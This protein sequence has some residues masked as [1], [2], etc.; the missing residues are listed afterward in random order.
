MLVKLHMV[1][2]RR[3][4]FCHGWCLPLLLSCLE[5]R[6]CTTDSF[7][8]SEAEEADGTFSLLQVA[9]TARRAAPAE[10]GQP[11]HNIS[12]VEPSSVVLADDVS[13]RNKLPNYTNTNE[14]THLMRICEFPNKF[15]TASSPQYE[16]Q[17]F[18]RKC[19]QTRTADLMKE[20]NVTGDE[21]I[22]MG[23]GDLV[24]YN[25]SDELIE[26]IM[27]LLQRALAQP[28]LMEGML[29][30]ANNTLVVQQRSSLHDIVGPHGVLM[31][32]LDSASARFDQSSRLLSQVGIHVERFG[33]TDDSTA[34]PQELAEGCMKNTS[35]DVKTFCL[36]RA[37][38][39]CLGDTE[40]AIALSH[41]K[42]LEWAKKRDG[43][44]TAVFEDDAV[45]APLENWELV[46]RDAWAKLPKT[47]KFVRLGW[48]YWE[49]D[50]WTYPVFEVP[51]AESNISIL[52]ESWK[53]HG[54][55]RYDP[56]GCTTAYMVHKDILDE[57]LN[58]FPCCGPVDSCY[59]WDFFKR[60]DPD[61]NKFHGL[62]AMLSLDSH[63][64]PLWDDWY[65]E[66]HG[67]FFQD[68]GKLDR[69]QVLHR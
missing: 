47:V 26:E 22:H 32:S 18:L 2:L 59:K 27:P 20:N 43:E 36:D 11:Q 3:A 25:M 68:R 4:I 37:G 38:Q 30:M 63:S 21:F 33:A 55:T 65:L 50:D 56:G 58:L 13:I 49:H 39:G 60:V 69:T 67:L 17:I 46:F 6:V 10:V 19:G 66:H 53:S 5:A 52:V 57:V 34:T 1:K 45:P 28:T 41:R 61:T 54:E 15:P 62:H 64:E 42:A 9:T 12:E 29:R 44:W 7:G 35:T 8:S 24:H 14:L 48:C 51:F 40:Q 23:H 16:V 31:I